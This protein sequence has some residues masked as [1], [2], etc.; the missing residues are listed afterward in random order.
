MS[1]PLVYAHRG[2]SGYRPEHTE[3]AYEVG[4]RRGADYIEPDLVMTS[5]GELVVRHEPEISETTDV[6]GHPEFAGRR[7][8][9]VIDGASVSGWFTE[10]FTL[11]ELKTLRAVERLP[12]LRPKNTGFD[13]R[14]EIMTFTEVLALREALSTEHGREI[15]V[16]PEIKHSGYFHAAGLDPETALMRE[17][18]GAGLNRADAPLWVQSFERGNLQALRSEHGYLA[19]LL[20]LVEDSSQIGDLTAIAGFADGIGPDKSLVIPRR[21]DDTLGEPTSLVDDAHAAGLNVTLWTFRSENAFLPA[22]YRLGTDP[23]AH[24]KAREELLAYLH[25]GADAVFC[26]QPDVGVAARLALQIDG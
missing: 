24:G 7:T 20:L 3:A 4:V 6:A 11:A 16:I 2:A 22:E 5:D 18:E 26:D 9:K 17:V 25:T 13:G 15:G 14:F 12:G 21:A 1:R 10:D 23:A 19:K 8:T